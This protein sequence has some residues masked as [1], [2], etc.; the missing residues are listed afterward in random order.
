M[1]ETLT[2]TPLLVAITQLARV[3]KHSS[4]TQKFQTH[5][6]R[7]H[8]TQYFHLVIHI[9]DDNGEKQM[10][11]KLLH[12]EHAER[13]NNALSNELSRLTQSND[14]GVTH[15]DAMDFIYFS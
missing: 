12:G 8:P 1:I 5:C 2:P 13:W 14:A 9:Y 10:L 15:Q 7:N 6:Q 11:D 3:I 4:L